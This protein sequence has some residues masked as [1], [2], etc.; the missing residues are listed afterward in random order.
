VR[1]FGVVQRSLDGKPISVTDREK[2]L[3]AASRQT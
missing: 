3:I 1:F 2:T